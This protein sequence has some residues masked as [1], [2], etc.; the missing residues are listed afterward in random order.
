MFGYVSCAISS[1]RTWISTASLVQVLTGI[2]ATCKPQ[3]L[4]SLLCQL[5]ED[6]LV[7]RVLALYSAGRVFKFALYV[8]FMASYGVCLG[9]TIDAVKVITG[10][11]GQCP[12]PLLKY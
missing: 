11:R 3:F 10:A 7:L 9:I 4:P 8:L 1:C 12:L 6:I 2:C 5:F